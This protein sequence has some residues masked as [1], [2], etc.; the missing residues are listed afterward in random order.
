MTEIMKRRHTCRKFTEEP[1]KDTEIDMLNQAFAETPTGANKKPAE[2]IC[3][4]DRQLINECHK[5]K[6][7]GGLALETAVCVYAVIVDRDKT[8]TW[9]EDGSIAAAY[10]MLEAESLNIGCCWLQI[11]LRENEK[12]ELEDQLRQL[13]HVPSNY[14]VLCLLAMGYKVEDKKYEDRQL[15]SSKIHRDTY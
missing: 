11:H 9:I 1:L 3:V 6:S 7:R 5:I 2:L 14:G 15:I 8:D 10:L 4:T 13:L 12:G